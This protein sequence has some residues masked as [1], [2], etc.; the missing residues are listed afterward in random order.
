MYLLRRLVA[1]VIVLLIVI[2]LTFFFLR[3][4]PGGPFDRDRVLPE[5]I[6]ANVEMKYGLD[7]PVTQ[8]YAKYLYGMMQGDL[9]PAFK[10]L[11]RSVNDV[12]ADAFPVSLRLGI[13]ALIVAILLG[14]PAGL[15]S[16]S[17][18]GT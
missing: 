3:F 1:G 9:G 2:T 17:R 8:Q 14:V 10:Y 15:I 11:G 7:Q 12:L 4:L 18:P 5:K 16:A 6:R 13:S